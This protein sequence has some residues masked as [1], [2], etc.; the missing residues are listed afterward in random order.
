[1]LS[2]TFYQYVS[3]LKHQQNRIV[4]WWLTKRTGLNRKRRYRKK[5]INE[6]I[7]Y[8]S[9]SVKEHFCKFEYIFEVDPDK[10]FDPY[11][12]FGF[13]PVCKEYCWPNLPSGKCIEYVF[14][15]GFRSYCPITKEWDFM[16]NGLGDEDKVYVACNDP[17]LAAELRI[18]Y[19]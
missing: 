12:P 19:G 16:F 15:R 17:L 10:F 7:G 9:S 3:F 6:N 4:D 13:V 8:R 11:E 5:W 18:K 14:N 1:M 2:T